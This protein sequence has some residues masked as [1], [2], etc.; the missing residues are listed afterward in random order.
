MAW[1][2]SA[3][4]IISTVSADAG[5]S[6]GVDD[7]WVLGATWGWES[8]AASFR[9]WVLA[10]AFLRV[11]DE[12]WVNW[13][14]ALGWAGWLVWAT[15]VGAGVLV[16]LGWAVVAAVSAWV[17]AWA[18]RWAVETAVLAWVDWVGVGVQAAD[19]ITAGGVWTIGGTDRARVRGDDRALP[20]GTNNLLARDDLGLRL[21]GGW[22]RSWGTTAQSLG[23]LLVTVVGTFKSASTGGNNDALEVV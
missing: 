13:T 6:G 11:R 21:R 2:G 9:S 8:N 22:L 18:P 20:V 12:A 4:S 10:K 7:A 16:A 19:I 14:T 23:A 5:L 1:E 17:V 3:A 15:A